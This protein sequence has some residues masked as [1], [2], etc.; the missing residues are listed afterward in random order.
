MFQRNVFIATSKETLPRATTTVALM[1]PG[2]PD[3]RLGAREVVDEAERRLRRGAISG[4]N[5][6]ISMQKDC[7]DES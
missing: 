7:P 1:V 6:S 4:P 5:S 2:A 3:G